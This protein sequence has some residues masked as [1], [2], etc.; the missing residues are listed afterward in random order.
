VGSSAVFELTCLCHNTIQSTQVTVHP[1][2]SPSSQERGDPVGAR[3]VA[4]PVRVTGEEHLVAG[5]IAR[6]ASAVQALYS[7]YSGIVR[8]ILVQALGSDRDID[9]LTQDTLITVVER[10]PAL[11]KVQSLRSFVI[12]VAIHLARNEIRRRRI[13]KFVGLDEAIDVPIVAPHDAASAQGARHLYRALDRMEVTARMA[14][15][16]RFVHGCDLAETAA[17]CG[18]SVATVKRKLNRAETRFASLVRADPVLHEFLNQFG[19]AS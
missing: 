7:Q 2:K 12:G 16:L 13:R 11:R 18:C 5:L 14:F 4:L 10:A 1:I 9:D 3:V 19:G 6:Q 17:A 15:V 8:R